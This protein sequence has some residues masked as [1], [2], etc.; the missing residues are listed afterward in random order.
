MPRVTSLLMAIAA[1]VCAAPAPAAQPNILLLVA[2]DLS[3]RIGAYGDSV[4]VTLEAEKNHDGKEN[5]RHNPVLWTGSAR[6]SMGSTGSG[7]TSFTGYGSC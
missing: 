1:L 3:P 6:R 5:S 7:S 4:A 2:E